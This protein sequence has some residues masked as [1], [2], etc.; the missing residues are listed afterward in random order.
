MERKK[1]LYAFLRIR[2]FLLRECF[3][4]LLEEQHR[5]DILSNDQARRLVI[6]E[7]WIECEAK[8]LPEAHRLLQVFHW[9]VDENFIDHT[10]SVAGKGAD[11]E[12]AEI[13][14]VVGYS[15][16]GE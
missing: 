4:E 14:L 16:V 10:E 13:F 6:R 7:L 12:G 8:V 11:A 9:Q 5:K 15:S 1:H 2:D 3:E